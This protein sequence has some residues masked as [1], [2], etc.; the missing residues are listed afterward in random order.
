MTKLGKKIGKADAL[1][2]IAAGYNTPKKVKDAKDSDLR[3]IEG[4]GTVAV[5]RIRKK[6]PR[7][8]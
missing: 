4:L 8:K 1:L 5:S 6:L 7:N 2:L 3:K